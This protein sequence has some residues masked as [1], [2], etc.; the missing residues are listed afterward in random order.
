VIEAT[1]AR[2]LDAR[3]PEAQRSR[4]VQARE[5]VRI[6]RAL[7]A[8]DAGLAGR[9]WLCLGRLTLA[10]IVLGVALQY[11]DFRYPHDW[12]AARPAL[13]KWAA[14]TTSR[15]SFAST[16]PPRITPVA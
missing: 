6:A 15:P 9:E 2:L 5:E 4:E 11:I 8:I 10:D 16:L 12:R 3:R 14:R 1:Q 7:D 13:A